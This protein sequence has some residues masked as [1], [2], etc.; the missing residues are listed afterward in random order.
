MD[1]DYSDLIK[2][3]HHWAHGVIEHHGLEAKQL[4]SLL[5]LSVSNPIPLGASHNQRPLIVAFMGGTGVGKSS[6]LNRLAG[7]SIA[8]TGIERPTSREITLY[9]HQS[10]SLQGLP[11]PLS[12]EK[13]TRAEHSKSQHKNLLWIDTPDFDSIESENKALVLQWL[14]YIDVL[15]YVVSPDRYKDQKAW[16]LLLAEGQ[17]HG[18]IFVF[19]QWDLAHPQQYS[20]FEKQLSAVGFKQPFIF[21]S[22][23]EQHH[24]DEFTPLLTC[25]KAL[26][27][28]QTLEVLEHRN[29]QLNKQYLQQQL[30]KSRHLLGSSENFQRLKQEWTQQWSQAEKILQKGLNWRIHR[31][32]KQYAEKEAHLFDQQKSLLL[33][34]EWAQNRLDSTLD[35]LILKASE[36]QIPPLS[37]RQNLKPI[38]QKIGARVNHTIDLKCRQAI[39]NPGH[40]LHRGLL[41]IS[42]V[43]EILLPL[44]TISFVGYQLLLGFYLSTENKQAYLGLDF[45]IHSFLFISIS[46]LLPY[47]I[48]KKMQP[49][50]EKSALK[51]LKQ[52][53]A[54]ANQIISEDVEEIID[55]S[56]QQ[57][58]DWQDE[59]TMLIEHC[60]DA[61]TPRS[62]AAITRILLNK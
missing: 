59:L 58:Q 54:Q 46:W 31:Q 18:W 32:A 25:I 56:Q 30:Q 49:S 35:E 28:R 22:S 10:Q 5:T 6:L 7:E 23:C 8:K 44:L 14:P 40:V 34:D 52:G 1:Y 29:T 12:S 45:A 55:R 47:F 17:K 16:V 37:L 15:I 50:I 4:E 57:Q 27:N 48:R 21:K 13:I 42:H 11:T 19:N 60:E 62:S 36:I 3:S 39:V 26:A 38:R 43:C 61:K 2:N 9:H 24:D 53:L 20:D 51:G 33:W 41:K